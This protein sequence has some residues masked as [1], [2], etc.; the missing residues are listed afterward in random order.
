MFKDSQI[1]LLASIVTILVNFLTLPFF[2]NYLSPSDYGIIA[3]FIL[4]GNVLTNLLSFGLNTATYGSFFK[5]K[6]DE[7]KILNFSVLFFLI[8]IFFIF[9]QLFINNF[10]YFIST[11]VFNNEISSDLLRLS[12]LNGCFSYFY[13]HFGQL[14][15]ARKKV[16]N[17]S[18]LSIIHVCMNALLTFYFIKYNS[19]T[20]LAGIYGI[21]IANLI[22]MCLAIISNYDLFIFKFS[23][24]LLKKAIV[25][26]IPEVPKLLV[27]LLYSSFD[28]T[29]LA[30]YKGVSEIG[31]YEFGSKFAGILK[32][33]NDA[34]GK[35]FSPF[36]QENI[37]NRTKKNEEYIL[38][39]FYKMLFY[40][41]FIAVCISYFGEEA[42]ILL[43]TKEFYIAKYLIPFLTLYYFFGVLS[44]LASNQFIASEKLY[45]LAPIS[46]VSL[47]LNIVL[48]IILI[49]FFGAIGA[50][51]S[52][53]LAGCFASILMFYY[54]NKA[55]KLSTN[56]KK[57]ISIYILVFLFLLIGYLIL[58]LNIFFIY[59]IIFKIMLLSAFIFLGLLF[60]FIEFDDFL[61]AK[62][63]FL[64]KKIQKK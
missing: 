55:L 62:N 14:L 38:N 23:K 42:L 9:N 49:P 2:T 48:N 39:F 40:L 36:F 47:M 35:S 4:F 29:M 59:K 43:T 61:Y 34:V 60:K 64:K 11:V 10:A 58:Y 24:V 13:A 1:Y 8:L 53:A 54:G 21:L 6:K 22:S 18:F 37:N 46:L 50:V 20:Y 7:L 33:F 56:N 12:F 30:N 57:I 44:Q 32:I 63:D 45:Y 31:Y 26:G 19:L 5:Y 15:I 52:T 17:F 25:Y 16:N 51:I 41:G 3:L 27:G 28:K